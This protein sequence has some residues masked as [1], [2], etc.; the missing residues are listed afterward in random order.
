MLSRRQEGVTLLELMVGVAVLAIALAMG[1]PSFGA[2]IRNTHNRTAAESI[3]NGLQLARAEAVRRNTL[4]RFDLT[5]A[6]GKVEWK[7]GCVNV[8]AACPANIQT[9]PA[10]EGSVDARVGTSASVIPSPAPAG[11][12]NTPVNPGTN[13]VAGISFNGLGRVPDAN[14]GNDITRAD[15]T[16]VS[17]VANAKRYVVL[18][19]RGGLIRMCDPA[20]DFSTNPQ[21]CS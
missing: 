5:D 21:G 3:V 13:A 7:V 20:L 14:V 16:H 10:A 19:S 2:W 17:G 9:R 6:G 18:V 8:T 12:F 4:V 1:L 11:F 15:I